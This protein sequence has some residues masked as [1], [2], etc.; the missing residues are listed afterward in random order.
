MS[1]N[2]KELKIWILAKEIAIETFHFTGKFPD[3]EKFGLVN[4]MRRSS[5]SIAS[6]I[7]EGSGRNS[8]KE[9]IQYIGIATGSLY[10]FETQ[11][12]IAD[13]LNFLTKDIFLNTSQ[14][15]NELNKMLY[16]FKS[17]FELKIKNSKQTKSNI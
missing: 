17:K 15:L 10:E 6:N 7:A 14:K 8:D 4:Q 5:V 9:F 16:V 1:H 3:S 13:E 2:Y 12:I 11:L